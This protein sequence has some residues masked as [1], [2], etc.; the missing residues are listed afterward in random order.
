[1]AALDALRSL[2]DRLRGLPPRTVG[3]D[4]RA[5]GR[6]G[7]NAAARLLRR[8]G[9][10]ILGRNVRLRAGEADLVCLAPDR[11]TIVVV[12]VKTRLVGAAAPGAF[13]PPPP[14]ANVHAH[15]RRTL[16]AVARSLARLNGWQNRPMR[17]DVVAVEW[18]PDG[19]PTLRHHVGAVR[20]AHTAK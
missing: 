20:S 3:R 8:S 13:R 16:A 4:G 2:L 11:A 7:E 5:L 10:K 19:P 15:K 9:Y 6:A 1:M 18:P 12:E 17:I 14:E